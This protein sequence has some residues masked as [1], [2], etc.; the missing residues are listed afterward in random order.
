MG[1]GI[2]RPYLVEILLFNSACPKSNSWFPRTMASNCI[3]FIS[4]MTDSP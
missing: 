2:R 1:R 3:A 4:S